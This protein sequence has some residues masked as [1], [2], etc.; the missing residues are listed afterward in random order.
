MPPR[1]RT[2]FENEEQRKEHR[3][4]YARNYMRQQREQM[5]NAEREEVRI[6]S[7]EEQQRE[8]KREYAQNYMSQRREQMIDLQRQE[9]RNHRNQNDRQRSAKRRAEMTVTEIEEEMRQ[10]ADKMMKHRAQTSQDDGYILRRRIQRAM[11]SNQLNEM[12][13][14]QIQVR[15]REAV[16]VS[17]EGMNSLTIDR[18][19]QTP[20]D[21]VQNVMNVDFQNHMENNSSQQ[22]LT[23]TLRRQRQLQRTQNRRDQG[24]VN[25]DGNIEI[26]LKTLQM[27]FRHGLDQ[28]STP[29]MCYI[30]QES[31]PAM[32]V[33]RVL[34]GP[35]CNQCRQEKNEHRFSASNNMDPGPQPLELANLTQIEEMLIARVNPILQVTHATRG[36]CKYKGHTISFPQEVREIA[37]ILPHQIKDLPIIIVRKKDQR[38]TNYNFTV[39]K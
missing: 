28:L 8:K 12:E 32:K 7:T 29:S 33:V 24:V 26:D 18:V 34:E 3:R 30:C 21:R 10:H 19:L 2:S 22:E 13:R 14:Q 23:T 4:E 35:I 9:E 5:A 37:K 36:Q 6:H 38:G 39:N 27:I 20:N 15:N 25:N 16:E 31:Y 1:P 11:H 17:S